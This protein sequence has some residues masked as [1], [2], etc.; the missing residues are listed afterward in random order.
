MALLDKGVSALFKKDLIQK[1]EFLSPQNVD[2]ILKQVWQFA[3]HDDAKDNTKLD[4]LVK[5][6]QKVSPHLEYDEIAKA[7]N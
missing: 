3:V 1:P 4:Q 6:L 5:L 2:H 7:F